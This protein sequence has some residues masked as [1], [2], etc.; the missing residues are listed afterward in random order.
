MTCWCRRGASTRPAAFSLMHEEKH[1]SFGKDLV[2]Q[3]WELEA[4]SQSPDG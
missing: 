1:H 3:I 4:L 2:G